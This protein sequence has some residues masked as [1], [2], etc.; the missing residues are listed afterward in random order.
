MST[1]QS[2]FI[3]VSCDGKG[4]DKSVTFAANPQGEKEAQ[5]ANPWLLTHRAIQTADKR[6]LTY[7]GDECEIKAA[8][9]G[10]HN[11]LEQKHIITDAN[12]SQV[13]LA[14]QAA[15]LAAEATAKMKEGAG[16]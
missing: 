10:A 3:T 16:R 4:C 14:A 2:V 9:D 1:V 5:D 12:N 6:V 11:K 13:N 8:G 15:K 7:C